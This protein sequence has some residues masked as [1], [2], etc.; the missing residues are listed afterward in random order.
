M[1]T[2]SPFSSGRGS[3]QPPGRCKTWGR[4]VNTKWSCCS[5][6][7]RRAASHATRCGH[8]GGGGMHRRTT[9]GCGGGA[10]ALHPLL[11][12]PEQRGCLRPLWRRVPAR[13]PLSGPALVGRA[14]LFRWQTEGWLRGTVARRSRAAVFS[15][16]VRYG[17]RS[18]LG[19]AVV[20]SLLDA[21]SHGPGGRCSSRPASAQARRPARRG[22]DAWRRFSGRL[23]DDRHGPEGRAARAGIGQIENFHNAT[24]ARDSGSCTWLNRRRA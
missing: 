4:R 2:S 5:T 14:V 9:S 10:V 16:V 1:T 11:R 18:A 15:H 22:T 24:N 7:G 6:A 3:C 20:E 21:A 13:G 19:A 23:R 12:P 17:P 8:C